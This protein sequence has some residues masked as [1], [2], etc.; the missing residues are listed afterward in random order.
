MSVRFASDNLADAR[1]RIEMKWKKFAAIIVFLP[2]LFGFTI[3]A[4]PPTTYTD[5]TIIPDAE[6]GRMILRFYKRSPGSTDWGDPVG[7]TLQGENSYQTTFPGVSPEETIEVTVDAY[8]DNVLNSG[9]KMDPPFVW[10]RPTDTSPPPDNTVVADGKVTWTWP[11]TLVDGTEIYYAE[12]DKIIAYIRMANQ[13]LPLDAS[14]YEYVGEVYHPATVFN[15][16]NWAS[17]A[18]VP[19]PRKG[20]TKY[21]S[22]SVSLIVGTIEKDGP[23]SPGVEY[24]VPF[25]PANHPTNVQVTRP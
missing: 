18:S 2:V 20:E 10:T 25:V 11:T 3:T 15:F 12:Y 24:T 22:V 19:P 9:P 23:F 21:F 1:R 16:T 13:E 7:E 6:K 4:T 17:S 8:I 5:N 14:N